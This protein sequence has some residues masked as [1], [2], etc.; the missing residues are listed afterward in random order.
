MSWD[1]LFIG[2]R[3][4]VAPALV[5]I[6]FGPAPAPWPYRCVLR[7]LK[8]SA[9]APTRNL[10]SRLFQGEL[11]GIGRAERQR[12]GVEERNARRGTRKKGGSLFGE[13]KDAPLLKA[14]ERIYDLLTAERQR[15]SSLCARCDVNGDGKITRDELRGA[16]GDLGVT[17][18]KKDT[19]ILM[20]LLDTDGDG[21]L[22]Y[23]EAERRLR[24][25]VVVMKHKYANAR[26]GSCT[27]Q[28]QVKL[29]DLM[30]SAK[31]IG[32]GG[33]D[34]A[35]IDGEHLQFTEVKWGGEEEE[36]KRKKDKKQKEKEKLK[37]LMRG[38]ASSEQQSRTK[39]SEDGRTMFV[40]TN[41]DGIFDT[42][43]H[44]TT[45]DGK[46]VSAKLGDQN[47]VTCF[48]AGSECTLW[49]RI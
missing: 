18:T 15:F 30:C 27:S 43:L 29:K 20:T 21:V 7:P 49:P 39:K 19:R 38:T 17:L 6:P 12:R 2:Q 3:R 10:H 25:L 14:I 13:R 33:E 37:M 23:L 48:A 31:V 34:T 16:L 42:E 41:G 40:D 26:S 8:L 47:M 5:R 24:D 46:F 11:Q 32:R 45:G 9:S 44:D 4:A 35:M 28:Q 36:E 22:E 1:I